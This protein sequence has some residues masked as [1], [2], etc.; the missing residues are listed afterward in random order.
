MAPR[1][2]LNDIRYLKKTNSSKFIKN[3]GF[4]KEKT[5]TKNSI[6]SIVSSI[7]S[8]LDNAPNYLPS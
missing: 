7:V 3:K 8:L 2:Y 5:M 1:F 6:L 4:L